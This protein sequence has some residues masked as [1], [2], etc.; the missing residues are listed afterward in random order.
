MDADLFAKACLD[1]LDGGNFL[2]QAQRHSV[3]AQVVGQCVN[4]LGID[5]IQQ[6]VTLVNEG[7][8]HAEGRKHR[9]VLAPD[10]SGAHHCHGLGHM[11]QL[12]DVVAGENSPSIEGD[13]G[14][15]SCGSPGS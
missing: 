3:L 13:V 6:A 4:H 9:G 10:D 14:G 1:R 7:Y 15:A 12:G 5:E 2:P 11:L 8:P